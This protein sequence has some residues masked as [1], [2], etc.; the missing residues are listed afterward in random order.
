MLTKILIALAVL[1][2]GLCIVAALQPARFNY[3]RSITIAAPPSA[4]FAQINDL[5]NFQNWNPWAKIDPNAKMIYSGP[6]AG[7]GASYQWVGN[8]DV[9]EGVMTITESRP[10]EIVRCRMDFKKPMEATNMAEFTFKPEG[11]QTVVTWGMSGTNKFCGKAFGLI[12]N[13]EKMV[14]TQF[15]KGLAT[16]KSLT[17]GPQK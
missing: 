14:G 10:S 16:L 6:D 8:K 5:H 13:C 11:N 1:V 15:E 7:V 3:T 9:G 2:I 17:E 4:L 12:V